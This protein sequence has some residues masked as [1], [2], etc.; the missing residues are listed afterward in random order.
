MNEPL[1][2]GALDDLRSLSSPTIA[3]AIETFGVR[4]REEGFVDSTVR[5]RFPELGPLVGYACTAVI[6]SGQPAAPKRH[7]RRRDYWAYV[8]TSPQPRVSVMQD[9]SEPVRGSF[10]GEVNAN[11]HR[12]LGC[13]GVVTNGAVRDLDEM[14]ALGFHAFAS[15]VTVSHAFAHLEDF[16]RPVRI[17]GLLVHPGDLLHADQHGVV[18]VPPEVARDVAARGREI[19]RQERVIIDLCQS[20]D[21]SLDKLDGFVS[22]AY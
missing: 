9:L 22:D 18:V 12:A 17:G 4:S 16:N 3:N 20:P 2:P 5:C 13:V 14:R 19:E 10:W 15:A 1:G 11:I 7:V 6:L 21:F 8:Q